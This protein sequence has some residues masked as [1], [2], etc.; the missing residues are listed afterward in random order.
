MVHLKLDISKIN[1]TLKLCD[2]EWGKKLFIYYRGDKTVQAKYLKT[3]TV[4]TITDWFAFWEDKISF[5]EIDIDYFNFATRKRGEFL[6]VKALLSDFRKNSDDEVV[7]PNK[8][9]TIYN[10]S[11][12]EKEDVTKRM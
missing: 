7:V 6:D 12:K 4:A 2:K 10:N 5:R 8:G 11:I 9:A 3:P 1:K